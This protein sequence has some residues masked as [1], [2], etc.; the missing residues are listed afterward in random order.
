MKHLLLTPAVLASG[1]VFSSCA[2]FYHHMGGRGY[3]PGYGGIGMWITWIIVIALIGFGAYYFFNKKG[4]STE[5]PLD[6][7][8]KRYARGEIT[9]EEFERIKSDLE[10]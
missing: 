5:T 8:K 10:L 9:K 1:L 3:Y 4:F 6:V 7:L 2:P